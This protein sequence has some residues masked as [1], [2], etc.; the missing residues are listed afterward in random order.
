MPEQKED[1]LKKLPPLPVIPFYTSLHLVL[2]GL[3]LFGI[4][5]FMIYFLPSF[6]GRSH[7]DKLSIWILNLFLGWSFLGWVIALIWAV[8]K[9]PIFLVEPNSDD[10][11]T[12]LNDLEKLRQKGVLNASEFENLK[13]RLVRGYEKKKTVSQSKKGGRSASKNDADSAKSVCPHCARE[14]K[15]RTR[16]LGKM[17]VC[18]NC[19]KKFKL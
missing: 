8:T 2:L 14:Y 16:L 12:Q 6:I 7:R 5:I 13:V 15:I 11:V 10:L 4:G 9:D 3:S 1:S 18:K 17:A 19:H